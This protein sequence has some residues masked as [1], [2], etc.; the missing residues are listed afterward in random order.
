[1]KLSGGS[2]AHVASLADAPGRNQAAA[3]EENKVR[4]VVESIRNFV[5][6]ADAKTGTPNVVPMRNGNVVL[7]PQELE[8]FKAEYTQEKSFRADYANIITFLVALHNRM[9]SEMDDYK[10]KRDSAHLWRAS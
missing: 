1:S 10:A 7:T 5:R 2:P 4:G 3:V 6:S 9:Q 8:A